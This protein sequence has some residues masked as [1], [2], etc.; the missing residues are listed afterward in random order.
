LPPV[1][2]MGLVT[3]S[4]RHTAFDADVVFHE[5]THGLTNRLVGG[6]RQGHALDEP[7]SS[8]MGE[9]WSDYFALTIQ[10]Y[11]RA[12]SGAPEKTVTGDWVV[13]NPRGIRTAP[14][15]DHFPKGYGDLATFPRV[16]GTNL[17]DEHQT[18]EVW[19]AALMMMTRRI[20]AALG[21]DTDGY[22]LAWVMVVDGLKL[23]PANPTFLQARDAILLAL[24]HLRDQRRI[25]PATYQA[26]L[27]AAWQAFAHFGM[28]ANAASEDAGVDGISAD[29]TQPPDV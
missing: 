9:G 3:R 1:M 23:T 25:A 12:Q 19:C 14:Y 2:N 5:Y 27:R 7:Q 6:T 8:G 28:G 4:A 15:D 21:S 13:N 20:R 18:G 17:P 22:R 26:A 24:D 11:F 29:T 16:P 10:N